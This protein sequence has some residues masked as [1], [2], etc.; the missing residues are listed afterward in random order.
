MSQVP[1]KMVF[2]ENMLQI[3]LLEEVVHWLN[4]NIRMFLTP[5]VISA[6][7][8]QTS[9]TFLYCPLGNWSYFHMMGLAVIVVEEERLELSKP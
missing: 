5:L 1:T 9:V 8:T 2:T 6:P 3:D 7:K 4:V